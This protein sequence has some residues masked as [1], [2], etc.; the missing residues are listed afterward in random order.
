MSLM[1]SRSD[2]IPRNPPWLG[3]AL[4]LLLVV[5]L[6]VWAALPT[7]A[8][9]ARRDALLGHLRAIS[10]KVKAYQER[11]GALPVSLK[12][13]PPEACPYAQ[14]GYQ[15]VV[16]DDHRTFLIVADH[17]SMD[18]KRAKFHYGCDEELQVHQVPLTPDEGERL[19]APDQPH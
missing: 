3:Y 4:I 11:T 6:F 2:S 8:N 18:E 9:H 1:E 14:E 13:I 12:E 7:P 15:L 10:S 5:G 17:V 16:Q 19:A